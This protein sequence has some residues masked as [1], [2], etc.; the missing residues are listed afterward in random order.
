M[1]SRNFLLLLPVFL[2]LNSVYS[3][4]SLLDYMV[5]DG[6]TIFGAIRSNGTKKLW[7]YEK[8]VSDNEKISYQK[9]RL[10]G[11]TVFRK[12][13]EVYYLKKNVNQKRS[14]FKSKG[15]Y[16]NYNTF[17]PDLQ[18]YVVTA[19]YD[20]IYGKISGYNGR[21]LRFRDQQNEEIKFKEDDIP[22][23]RYNSRIYRFKEKQLTGYG[24]DKDYYLMLLVEGKVNL[25]A[26]HY[27]DGFKTRRFYYIEKGDKLV[28][29][30]TS[31]YGHILE[32]MFAD[33]PQL[34]ERLRA[35]EFTPDNMVLIVKLYN[36]GNDDLDTQNSF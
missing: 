30:P 2:I 27:G 12:D 28:K 17:T 8:I 14:I 26:H 20:T 34:I 22:A 11:A 9:H 3:Q 36:E 29:V 13:G 24:D 4:K 10:K 35:R 7:L 1:R 19:K 33:A 18:D 21:R 5:K 6:D 25:Y 31:G 15:W 16:K 32:E 23:L